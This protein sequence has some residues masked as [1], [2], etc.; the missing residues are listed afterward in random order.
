MKAPARN[1]ASGADASG[2]PH[3]F[4]HCVF[5]VVNHDFVLGDFEKFNLVGDRW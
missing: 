3:P 1:H 2:I 4:C 5:G